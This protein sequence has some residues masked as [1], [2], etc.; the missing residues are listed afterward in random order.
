MSFTWTV[1]RHYQNDRLKLNF[2]RKEVHQKLIAETSVYSQGASLVAW[3]FC[4]VNRQPLYKSCDPS[5]TTD[6]QTF[7]FKCR[8]CCPCK[9]HFN[10]QCPTPPPFKLPKKVKSSV[11][12][13]TCLQ[14][15]LIA[16]KQ[17]IELY[18]IA[19]TP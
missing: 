5:N 1:L 4:L 10:T 19:I 12:E 11:Q 8:F 2:K 7:R 14:S 6:G 9:T 17:R 16:H 18:P 3:S 15:H 13:I